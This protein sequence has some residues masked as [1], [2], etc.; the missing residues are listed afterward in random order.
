[1]TSNEE[2]EQQERAKLAWIST[3]PNSPNFTPA[4]VHILWAFALCSVMRNGALI[5][6]LR[7]VTWPSCL[8]VSRDFRVLL[9][10]VAL[11]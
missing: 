6:F 5:A 10:E 7:D 8:H 3:E 4:R 11:R 2:R 1:M 9:S